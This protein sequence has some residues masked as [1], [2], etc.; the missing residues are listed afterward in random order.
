MLRW[1]EESQLEG[2]WEMCGT[3][4]GEGIDAWSEVA[5]RRPITRGIGGVWDVGEVEW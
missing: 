4:V 1:V 2:G 3:L 5:V